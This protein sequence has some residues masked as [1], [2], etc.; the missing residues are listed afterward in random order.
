MARVGVIGGSGLYDMPGLEVTGQQKVDTPFGMPSAPYMLGGIDGHEIVFLSRHGMQHS[1]PP[2]KVNYRAN[3]HGMMLLSVERII[4]VCACGGINPSMPPGAIVAL[5]QVL[6][7]TGGMREATIFDGG[8][9]VHVDFT[10]P[11]CAEMRSVLIASAREAGVHLHNSGTYVCV[12]GPRLESAAEIRHFASIGADVVGMTGMPEAV[13][14]REHELCYSSL[15]VVTNKAAG[16]SEGKLTTEEVMEQMRRSTEDVKSIIRAA[17][18]LM[19]TSRGCSCK[20]ALSG[21]SM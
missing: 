5:D 8:Q 17:L 2:H 18:A 4:A 15:A 12:N 19:P 20:D 16:I 21:S 14:A 13:L 11:Y 7:F 6:D 10:E 3:I 1:Q 9:V